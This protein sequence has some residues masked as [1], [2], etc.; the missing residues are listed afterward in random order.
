MKL[1]KISMNEINNPNISLR[2]ISS[3]VN[4]F[5]KEFQQFVD[6]FLSFFIELNKGVGIAAPQIGK[7]IRVAIINSKRKDGEEPFVIINPEIIEYSGLDSSYD[8]GCLSIPGYKGKVIRKNLLHV[9]YQDRFANIIEN[10]FEGFEARV[11]NHEI[12]H[13]NGILYTDRMNSE[14]RVYTTE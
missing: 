4:V 5:D 14:D 3:E 13:L 2:Q 7:N 6:D 9:R 1:I 11:F 12:D 10:H 8:E